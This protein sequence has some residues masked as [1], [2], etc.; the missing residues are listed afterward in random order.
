MVTEAVPADQARERSTAAAGA[1]WA[2]LPLHGVSGF[3]MQL[4]YMSWFGCSHSIMVSG[5]SDILCGG[6]GL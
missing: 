3:L 2:P 1:E 4:F 6:S 5:Y